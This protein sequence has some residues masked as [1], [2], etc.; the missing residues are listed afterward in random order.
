M[1]EKAE[2]KKVE[3]KVSKGKD[4][5]ATFSL[6]MLAVEKGKNVAFCTTSPKRRWQKR[7]AAGLEVLLTT[8]RQV[9]P[10]KVEAK[11]H[12]KGRR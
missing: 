1:L 11:V 8:F 4:K 9:A 7:G 3:K 2:D 10:E 5:G 12:R 6:Q